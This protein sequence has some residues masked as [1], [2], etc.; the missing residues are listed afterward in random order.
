[1]RYMKQ[2]HGSSVIGFI[3][4][5][6]SFVLAP[7]KILAA[8]ISERSYIPFLEPA[9]QSNVVVTVPSL[10]GGKDTLCSME[11]TNLLS[12]MNLFT[13]EQ[14][15]IIG[16][17]L[18]KYKNVTTNSGPPGTVLVSCYKTNVIIPP[19]Y[20]METNSL[21]RFR[22]NQIWVSNFQYTNKE[23]Q[24]EIR[25]SGGFSAKFTTKSNDGYTASITR[26]G[27]GSLLTVTERKQGSASG[28]LVRFDDSHAQGMTWDYKFADFSKGHLQEYMQ[29]TNGMM[30]GKWLMW[31]PLNNRLILQ[32]ECKT[33]Y[34]W[35]KHR[36]KLPL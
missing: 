2:I 34:D 22:T 30:L 9:S 14:Q 6:L 26:T 15:K 28:L 33:P 7:C 13:P 10:S 16:E 36:M 1:M 8:G 4:L 24:E 5:V 17:A 25:F 12:N 3:I 18:V 31:N 20:W 35:N 29:T 27:S 21:N 19:L 32:A 23:A 11:Y